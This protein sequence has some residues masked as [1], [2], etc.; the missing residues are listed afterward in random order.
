[1]KTNQS[2]DWEKLIKEATGKKKSYMFICKFL[3]K[4]LGSKYSEHMQKLLCF[5]SILYIRDSKPNTAIKSQKLWRKVRYTMF[6]E[7]YN[8]KSI[9]FKF[10]INDTSASLF[11]HDC[12]S[13]VQN[14][15]KLF[16]VTRFVTW[17]LLKTR[18]WVVF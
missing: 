18:K 5:G 13:C 1:M 10:T 14:L 8:F 7:N 3:S 12:F 6:G 11:V 16:D 4:Q 15:L 9:F 2:N 17:S